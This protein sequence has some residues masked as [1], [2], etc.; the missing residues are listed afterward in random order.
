[1]NPNIY[2]HIPDIQQR[3]DANEIKDFVDSTLKRFLIR[4]LSQTILDII[5]R[6]LLRERA[7]GRISEEQYVCL[8]NVFNRTFK[9][10]TDA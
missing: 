1:M 5:I 6:R 10:S 3:D 7:V 4:K 9:E 8:F 2:T